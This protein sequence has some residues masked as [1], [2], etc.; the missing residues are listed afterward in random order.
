MK[1]FELRLRNQNNTVIQ[2]L[3]TPQNPQ[4]PKLIRTP[5]IIFCNA[6]K[7]HIPHTDTHS[8]Q[9]FLLHFIKHK[10]V[11]RFPQLLI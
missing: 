4:N 6:I 10:Q 8:I 9:L 7:N 2:N 1:R 3:I 5:L 11:A